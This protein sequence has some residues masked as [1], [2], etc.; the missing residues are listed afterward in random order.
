MSHYYKRPPVKLGGPVTCA[1]RTSAAVCNDLVHK[2]YKTTKLEVVS[3]TKAGG[4]EESL[5]IQL[6]TVVFQQ[7]FE[8]L[9]SITPHKIDRYRHSNKSVFT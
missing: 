9:H 3:N 4:R 5:R 7:G 1:A 2:E 8:L 6:L